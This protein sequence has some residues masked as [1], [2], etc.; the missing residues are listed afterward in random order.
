LPA[1]LKKF[2]LL[3]GP[4][5]IVHYDLHKIPSFVGQNANSDG[6]TNRSSVSQ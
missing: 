2:S 1:I 5:D 4:N 3:S 6:P